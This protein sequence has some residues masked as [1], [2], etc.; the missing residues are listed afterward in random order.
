MATFWILGLALHAAPENILTPLLSPPPT[1]GWEFSGGW[2]GSSVR[3]INL[4]K[5]MK[6]Y[7]IKISI[8]VKVERGR[9]GGGS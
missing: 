8:G 7:I 4:K 5:C 9:G 3:P 2:G 6:L 1:K